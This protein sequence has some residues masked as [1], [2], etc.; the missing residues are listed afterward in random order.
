MTGSEIDVRD[1]ARSLPVLQSGQLILSDELRFE[2]GE[3]LIAASLRDLAAE[4]CDLTSDSYRFHDRPVYG[5]SIVVR[6][7]DQAR[8]HQAVERLEGIR[9]SLG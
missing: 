3:G 7:T 6:G 5:T 4:L 9:R 8:L 1:D 2:V